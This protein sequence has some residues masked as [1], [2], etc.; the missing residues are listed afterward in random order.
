ML[1]RYISVCLIN[2][3]IAALLGLALRFSFIENIGINYRFLTHAHSHVAM[4]GWVYLMI[5]TLFV[6]YFTDKN[7]PFYNRLFWVTQLS[8][9]GMLF[10]FPF[11]GYA[12]VSITFSTLHIIC[13]YFFAYA[14][15]KDL[16]IKNQLIQF[17]VK[18]A[19]VFM[20]LSTIGIWCLGPAVGLMGKASAFYQVAIQ[21][22]LHFQ[23]NGWFLIAV[24]ALLFHQ[25]KIEPS[26][27]SKRFAQVLI[28]ATVL[29]LALPV[30]WYV[31]HTVFLYINALGIVLQLWAL[32][33]FLKLIKQPYKIM[34]AN[35]PRLVKLM[36]GFAL[37][38]FL[39]KLVLQAATLFP[40]FATTL[41]N[42]LN[43][44]I[45]FIHLSMLGVISGFLF[46]FILKTKIVEPKGSTAI[47][48]YLFLTGFVLTELLLALQGS[49]FYFKIGFIKNYYLI[50]F[51]ASIFLPLGIA[52]ILYS[53]LKTKTHVYQTP[54][55][56]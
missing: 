35:Q 27:Y 43:F 53:F 28:G 29:T 17:L 11:Q 38:C 45:G 50:L 26:A 25:L 52:F 12:L 36:Y 39:I 6:H 9:V 24:L 19:L 32:F 30:Q 54:K 37:S 15:W 1:K 40:A 42:H 18:T 4:L 44:I 14:I 55:T 21:F 5:Y 20:L 13:S 2:F 31:N 3:L 7:S 41:I 16:N 22:F 51:I 49:Y 46:S 48:I 47:G 33:L 8:V 56:P 23:F 34:L 10:S